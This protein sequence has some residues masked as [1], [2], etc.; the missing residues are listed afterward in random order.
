MILTGKLWEFYIIF[1]FWLNSW[2]AFHNLSSSFL[3]HNLSSSFFFFDVWCLC[4]V[5]EARHFNLL[6][7]NISHAQ[8]L[9]CEYRGCVIYYYMRV[10]GIPDFI[11]NLKMILSHLKMASTPTGGTDRTL[12]VMLF[13]L[14]IFILYSSLLSFS[15]NLTETVMLKRKSLCLSNCERIIC[16]ARVLRT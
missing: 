6:K 16:V 13:P 5:L 14:A 7:A 9:D 8:S 1:C 11:C 4:F 10:D 12:F 15:W 2:N 3:M